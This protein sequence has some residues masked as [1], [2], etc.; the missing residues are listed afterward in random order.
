MRGMLRN[1]ELVGIIEN[2]R[3]VCFWKLA[4]LYPTL[5]DVRWC[6]LFVFDGVCWFP[7]CFFFRISGWAEVSFV[8]CIVDI[9]MS[10]VIVFYIWNFNKNNQY[11]QYMYCICIFVGQYICG[12]WDFLL[13]QP[14]KTWSGSCNW[15]LASFNLRIVDVSFCWRCWA[16]GMS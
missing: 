5:Y 8:C 7:L 13:R 9:A 14:L 10:Y 6:W 4:L 12:F 16:C 3:V 15:P 11:L 1:E 2:H